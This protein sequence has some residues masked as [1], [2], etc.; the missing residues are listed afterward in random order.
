MTNGRYRAK[1]KAL[2][3]F[4]ERSS[5][6][7]RTS[8]NEAPSSFAEA[9]SIFVMTLAELCCPRCNAP[10][11]AVQSGLV[12]CRYCGA[13]LVQSLQRLGPLAPSAE[14]AENP[15]FLTLHLDDAGAD[16]IAVIHVV[17]EHLRLGLANSRDLVNEAPCV[18]AKAMEGGS[19]KAFLAALAKAGAKVRAT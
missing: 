6:K 14:D 15:G 2:E 16:K 7:L 10:V 17:R 5:A 18:L 8:T 3:S 1:R 13:S 19:A 11:D 9:D 12:K 4:V